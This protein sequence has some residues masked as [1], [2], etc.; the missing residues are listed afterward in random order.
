M[1]M[2]T[3]GRVIVPAIIENLEDQFEVQK[4]VRQPETLRRVEVTD[5]LV[6]A[7]FLSMPRRLIQQLGL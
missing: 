3:M 6:G 4:G 1:Q 7:T 2:A 5:A